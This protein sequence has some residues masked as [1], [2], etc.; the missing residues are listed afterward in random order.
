M[1]LRFSRFG[2]SKSS[3]V[4]REP[5]KR[6]LAAQSRILKK[7]REAMP[8]LS[9]W[10]AESQVSPE[11]KA[12]KNE[13]ARIWKM[14]HLRDTTA[15]CWREAR[16]ILREHPDRLELAAKWNSSRSPADPSYLLD[17]IRQ[18]DKRKISHK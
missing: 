15:K 7:Q 1:P 5:T 2:I 14:I 10:V 12:A 11:E 16:R 18:W 17:M 13:A 3:T 9:E 8:L 4:F 6:K